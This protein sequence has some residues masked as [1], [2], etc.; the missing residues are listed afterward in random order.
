MG[1]GTVFVKIWVEIDEERVAGNF[2]ALE[3]VLAEGSEGATSL[4]AVVKANA[5]GHGIEACAPMLARA[6]AGWLGVTDAAEGVAVRTALAEAGIARAAQPRILVMSGMAGLRGG[7]G[8]DR[9]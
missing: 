1:S 5:Y 3:R 2:A 6:G 8:G 7:G 9:P 4:L